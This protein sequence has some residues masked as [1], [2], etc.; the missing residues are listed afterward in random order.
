MLCIARFQ[1]GALPVAFILPS[2]VENVYIFHARH[3]SLTSQHLILLDVSKI[4]SVFERMRHDFDLPVLHLSLNKQTIL[5]VCKNLI[6]CG[7][8]II[9]LCVM[10]GQSSQG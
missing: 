6:S 2:T 1:S 5:T 4:N 9:S 7:I 3:L 8:V 10:A